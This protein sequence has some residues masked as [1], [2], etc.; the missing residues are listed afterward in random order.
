[1]EKKEEDECMILHSNVGHPIAFAIIKIS[2]LDNSCQ[3]WNN[4]LGNNL[5]QPRVFKTYY[6]NQ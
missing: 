4:N 6:V 3:G 5:K 1:M 2:I